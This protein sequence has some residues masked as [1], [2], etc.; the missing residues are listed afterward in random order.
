MRR[1]KGK[2]RMIRGEKNEDNK[3]EEEGKKGRIRK[4][5]NYWKS[6]RRGWR[7]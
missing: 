7:R 2:R 4:R 6:R 1:E 3:E 5:R